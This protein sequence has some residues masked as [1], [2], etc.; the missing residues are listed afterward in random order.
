MRQ[1][2]FAL[3][4]VLILGV[5]LFVMGLGAMYM[6]EMGFRSVY[7]EQR[8][9]MGEKA[10]NY[11]IMQAVQKLNNTDCSGAGGSYQ[12]NGFNVQ[13]QTVSAGG[14]CFI[15]SSATNGSSKIVKVGVLVVGNAPSDY[16]AAVFRNLSNLSMSGSAA[17][18][19]CDTSCRTSA[20]ITGNNLQSP[21]QENLVT[22]CPNNPKGVTALVDPYV[23]VSELLNR[24]LTSSIFNGPTDRNGLIQTLSSNFGVSFNN[25]T[26]NG[27]V[28]TYTPITNQNG[29]I[30]TTKVN[31]Q[32]PPTYDVCNALYNN[33]S[34]SGNTITCSGN[35]NLNFVW[36]GTGYDVQISGGNTSGLPKNTTVARC[37]KID[38]GQNA[39]ITFNGFTGGG[40]IAGN[41]INFNGSVSASGSLTLVARNEV[42]DQS[43]NITI[44]NVNLFAQNIDLDNNGLQWNGGVLYSGGAGVGNFDI[45]LNSNSQ[46]GSPQNPVLIISDNNI[47]IERNGNASINGIVYA[48]EANNNLS[49]SGNGT[50]QLNG[51]L[52]SNS[53]NNN[54]ANISGNFQIVFNAN[55]IST[56]A[57]KYSFINPPKCAGTPSV[58]VPFIQTKT[59]VY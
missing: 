16:G 25:G 27:I 15:W 34:A 38:F 6:S 56:L 31:S 22:T 44:S 53:T 14:A 13:V 12:V 36:N 42:E 41:Q 59:T 2:G 49:V 57:Q 30:D 10:A 48:T 54:N 52:V 21:P 17:I 5:A 9:H 39:T 26:P 1:K 32:N 24:N 37:S 3:A 8:W 58:A 45:D 47:E 28:G 18:V 4:T 43:N 40:V 23:V 50:F 51:M 11:G 55:I 46:L 7:S 20:L 33:C 19:S 35:T 29:Q